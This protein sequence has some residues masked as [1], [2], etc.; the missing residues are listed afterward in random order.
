MILVVSGAHAPLPD[1]VASD[2]AVAVVLPSDLSRPGWR[3]TNDGAPA[4]PEPFPAPAALTGILCRPVRVSAADLPAIHADD[5]DYV[6]AEMT[7]F[8]AAFLAGLGAPLLNQPSPANLAGP[9]FGS[10][11]WLRLADRAGLPVSTDGAGTADEL[12][13]VGD[14]VLDVGGGPAD[15]GQAEVVRTLAAASGAGL[16]GVLFHEGAVAAVSSQPTLTP[17]VWAELRERLGRR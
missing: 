11:V 13:C 9:P 17:A 14:S 16:L 8:L 2:P 5:R 6:A 7:A 10:E 4:L 15:P 3:W 12:V 1:F